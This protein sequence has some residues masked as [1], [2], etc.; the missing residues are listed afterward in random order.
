MSD[1]ITCEMKCAPSAHRGFTLVELM[2][3]LLIGVFLL[4]GLVTL[5]GAMKRASVAQSGLA[6]LQDNERLAMTLLTNVIESTGYYP[7]PQSVTAAATFPVVTGSF[8]QAGQSIFGSGAAAAAA[9]G[10]SITV[11][12]ATAGNVLPGG[13]DGVLDCTGNISTTAKTFVVQFSIDQATS[14]LVCTLNGGTPLHLVT[15][16]T[17]MQIYYGVQTNV[18]L[19]NASA[20]SYLDATQVTNWSNVISVKIKLYFTN[21]ISGQPAITFTRVIK[22]LNKSGF[23]V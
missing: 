5:V 19:N 4:G 11:R 18:A 23:I 7:S 9:P 14:D 12:Y 6:T 22:L 10:D 3:T 2:V 21:P 8:T 20:D 16:I 13:N 1:S 17:R 15:G